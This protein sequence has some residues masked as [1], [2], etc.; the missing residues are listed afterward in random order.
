MKSAVFG[1]QSGPNR[2]TSQRASNLLVYP[3]GIKL[4]RGFRS[5]EASANECT[6][7]LRLCGVLV[8]RCLLCYPSVKLSNWNADSPANS[9]SFKFSRSY[10]LVH[11]AS[12]D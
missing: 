5:V 9:D 2:M 6:R 7:S 10:D 8:R 12:T 1:K 11:L 4:P 3:V